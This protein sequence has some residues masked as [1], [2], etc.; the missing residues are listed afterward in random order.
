MR[1]D[2]KKLIDMVKNGISDREIMKELGIQTRSSLKK[3]YLDALVEAGKIRAIL[4]EQEARKAKVPKRTVRIGTRGTIL[5]SRLLLV[6]QY[7]FQEGD[8]FTVSKRKDSI[9]LKKEKTP[10]ISEPA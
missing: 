5:L 8:T 10:D 1:D 9:V 7:G 4:T 3:M 6:D 2:Y